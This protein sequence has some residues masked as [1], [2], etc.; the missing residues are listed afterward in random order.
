MRDYAQLEFTHLLVENK[1]NGS[2]N[3]GESS[4]PNAG[5][6]GT[7]LK[8]FWDETALTEKSES[9][10]ASFH[11]ACRIQWL[12]STP[13]PR[14]PRG[15]AFPRIWFDQN[16]NY[17]KI[18]IHWSLNPERNQAWYLNK[19]R[20]LTSDQIAATLDGRFDAI[21]PGL[22]YQGCFRNDPVNQ[23]GNID[24]NIY[25]DNGMPLFMDWDLGFTD[26]T[27]IG[28]FQLHGRT[29][30]Y[31]ADL[32]VNQ[33]IPELIDVEIKKKLQEIGYRGRTEDI[34][35]YS[36]PQAGHTQILT[37]R[38][39]AN[40]YA[41][42]GYMLTWIPIRD[43]LLGI[44]GVKR[45]FQRKLILFHP[46]CTAS[47]DAIQNYRWPLDRNSNPVPGRKPVHNW[48]S[49]SCDR[50]R[51]MVE[52]C[53]PE[54]LHDPILNDVISVSEMDTMLHAEKKQG[55]ITAGLKQQRW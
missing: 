35:S 42:L 28:F 36:D 54:M 32:E 20:D 38:T 2:M 1:R 18:F 34:I 24:R 48:T 4:N 52:N 12:L 43:V 44:Q 39:M 22:V 53:M 9:I 29:A 33:T 6:G 13:N 26:A 27:S 7:F 50:I 23:G 31:I 45:A 40:T 16:N 5:A 10:Y 21:A 17:K 3:F 55:G 37:G 15:G 8:G 25:Y 41:Q 14:N 49:H 11:E 51:Y 47:I 46:R 30:H 19:C